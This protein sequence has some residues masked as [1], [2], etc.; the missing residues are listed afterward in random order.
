MHRR[1]IPAS[2]TLAALCLAFPGHAQIY[3]CD[4]GA[5]GVL[6]SDEACGENAELVEI[7]QTSPLQPPRYR[8]S[9]D[10]TN[11]PSDAIRARQARAQQQQ[12][13]ASAQRELENRIRQQAARGNVIAGMGPRDVE[14][15]WGRPHSINR[16]TDSGGETETWHYRNRGRG[17]LA[18]PATVHFRDG[19]VTRARQWERT[20]RR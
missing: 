15:A 19:V 18:G 4:D 20:S 12:A 8:P 17:R 16:S 10:A 6:F 11:T 2:A 9:P 14:R 5:G 7:Q 3:R 1:L 13:E